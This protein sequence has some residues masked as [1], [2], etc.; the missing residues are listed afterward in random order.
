ML[1]ISILGEIRTGASKTATLNLW[2]ED[3]EQFRAHVGR[4]PWDS[5][6]S[7]GL[8]GPEMLITPEE[9]S[10]RGAGA[11]CLPVPQDELARKKASMNEQGAFPEAPRRKRESMSCGITDEQ[12]RESRR[13]L[14]GHAGRKFERQKPSVNSIWLLR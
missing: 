11:D 8:S 5:G 9:G 4:V 3:F 12:L 14:L 13:K 10:L 2:R 1:A 6:L 7:E